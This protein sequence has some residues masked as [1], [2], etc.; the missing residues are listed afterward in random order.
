M[1]GNAR[2]RKFRTLFNGDEIDGKF[3]KLGAGVTGIDA[4]TAEYLLRAG[5]IEEV[6]EDTFGEL[7]GPTKPRDGRNLD[8][9]DPNAGGGE[10]AEA[11]RFEDEGDDEFENTAAA[12]F[13]AGRIP[14]D[15]VNPDGTEDDRLVSRADLEKIAEA[16]KV[17][18][19]KS[20]DKASVARAI[21]AARARAEANA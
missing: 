15:L 6:D 16:E 11:Q 17:T 21:M 13:Q 4:A 3:Y 9:E 8:G 12:D 5:R 2:N 18:F 7:E 10:S 20:G 19:R 1:P 14:D